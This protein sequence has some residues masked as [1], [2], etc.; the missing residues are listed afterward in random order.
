MSEVI[1]SVTTVARPKI[2]NE[3]RV[4]TAVRLPESI[5]RR[6]REEAFARDVSANLLMVRAIRGY[7]DT[8]PPVD[9]VAPGTH[10]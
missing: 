9:V 6:L 4:P 2:S 7:L 3:P 8:L 10:Q 1:G 5:H